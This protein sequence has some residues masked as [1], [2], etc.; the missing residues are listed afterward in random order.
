[1]CASW[2]FKYSTWNQGCT[3]HV[4]K[5]FILPLNPQPHSSPFWWLF[6]ECPTFFFLKTLAQTF[7]YQILLPGGNFPS[8]THLAF[9]E[10]L[11]QQGY[12]LTVRGPHDFSWVFL[13][14][15]SAPG[16]ERKT[17]GLWVWAWRSCSLTAIP[18]G[19]AVFQKE[20]L[21]WKLSLVTPN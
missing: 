19:S 21:R 7:P 3:M 1:M 10:Q 8:G 2:P 13:L 11:H 5:Q 16:P 9:L 6:S 4:G 15:S 17:L 14:A 18:S 12:V 20:D